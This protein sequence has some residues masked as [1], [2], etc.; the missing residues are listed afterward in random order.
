MKRTCWSFVENDGLIAYNAYDMLTARQFS[1]TAIKKKSDEKV[2][3]YQ[4]EDGI[5]LLRTATNNATCSSEY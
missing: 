5:G 3:H 2:Q 4:K 1:A